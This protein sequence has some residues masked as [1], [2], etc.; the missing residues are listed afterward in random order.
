[1]VDNR[2]A[3]QVERKGLEMGSRNRAIWRYVRVKNAATERRKPL[4]YA[5]RNARRLRKLGRWIHDPEGYYV[6]ALVLRSA[7]SIRKSAGKVALDVP[8]LRVRYSL[9]VSGLKRKG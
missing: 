1:M 8:N 2:K 7:A 5:A 4:P 3:R 9:A 6:A